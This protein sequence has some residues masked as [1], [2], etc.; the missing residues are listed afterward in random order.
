MPIEA[1]QDDYR[2]GI[3]LLQFIVDSASLYLKFS[4][5]IEIALDHLCGQQG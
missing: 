1:L 4:V 2:N 5:A 3:A